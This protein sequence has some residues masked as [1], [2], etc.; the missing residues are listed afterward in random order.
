MS[1][2]H[3]FQHGDAPIKMRRRTERSKQRERHP[4]AAWS[5]RRMVLKKR[6]RAG[7]TETAA[8]RMTI[9][10]RRHVTSP[11]A[12]EAENVVFFLSKSVSVIY[13]DVKIVWIA[14]NAQKPRRR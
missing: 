2:I 1:A 10:P 13:L 5:L 12:R 14:R 8:M 7:V 3:T 6:E 4:R 9:R 11:D